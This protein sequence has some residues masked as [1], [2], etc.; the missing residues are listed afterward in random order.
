VTGSSA[1]SWNRVTTISFYRKLRRDLVN[2]GILHNVLLAFATVGAIYYAVATAISTHH[3]SLIVYW[4]TTFAWPPLLHVCYLS[5]KSHWVPVRY[6]LSP[7]RYIDRNSKTSNSVHDGSTSEVV[8]GEVES[9]LRYGMKRV[10][11]DM[12]YFGRRIDIKD[13]TEF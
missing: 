6:L 4:L 9:R 3:E 10:G 13:D 8:H 5:L 11:R 2:N 7:P 12:L 1:N